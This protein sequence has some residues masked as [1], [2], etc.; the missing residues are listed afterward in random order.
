MSEKPFVV[1]C[2]PAFN[3]EKTIAK[4]VIETMKYAGKVVVAD[5]GS[6]DMTGVIAVK[7]GADVISHDK[8][9]GKGVALRSACSR[10]IEL[11]P[12]VVV[13][14]DADGQHEPDQIP[15]LV[16]PIIDGEADI[17]VGSR[18]VN[19]SFSDIPAYRRMGLELV[20]WL[21]RRAVNLKAKD[22]Q[23]GF[24]A[25]SLKALRV[26]S[27]SESNGY[28]VDSESLALAAKEGL[29]I[30]E[31]PI[32]VKYNLPVKTS[33]KTPLAHGMEIVSSILKVIIEDRPLL[34]LGV[35][36]IFALMIGVFFGI[37]IVQIYTIE[38]QIV[39]N[40]AVISMGFILAGLFA[41]FTAIT[42]YALT[43]QMQKI[44]NRNNHH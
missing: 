35:P 42:L 37:W 7:L 19:G 4:V 22:S 40:I 3:E 41:I 9:M 26:A 39:T 12:D 21:S 43:R 23:S 33:K 17:V 14:L 25:Y 18:Y 31:V 1:A 27:F 16:R 8:N 6:T 5:D 30:V 34:F 24:R 10:A 36:G 32:T 2:I 11:N 15:V 29:R 20:N 28:G 13:T 38:H 44:N